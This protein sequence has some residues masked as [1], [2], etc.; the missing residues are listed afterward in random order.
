MDETPMRL[1]MPSSRTLEFS[2]SRTVPVKSCGAEKRSFTV[3]LAVA[4]DGKRLPPKD[5]FKR[6]RTPRDLVVPDSRMV[7][8][9]FEFTPAGK[10]KAP[11]RNLV[12]PWIK[13]SW[14]EIPEE[15]AR[16]SFLTCGIS[17]ALDGTKDDAIYEEEQDNDAE[18]DEMDEEFDTEGEDEP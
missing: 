18:E 11:S 3:M 12:Q 6:V 17:N 1:E 7:T 5:I 2:G 9:P 13:Q 10:K 16:K 14:W 4:A 8:G 15:M